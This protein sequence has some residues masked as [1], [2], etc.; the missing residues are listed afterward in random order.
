MIVL[1]SINMT[2]IYYKSVLVNNDIGE[3]GAYLTVGHV[4]R[5]ALFCLVLYTIFTPVGE[6][7]G[8]T[9]SSLYALFKKKLLLLI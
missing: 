9:I 8:I 5:P 6:L 4:G 3:G 2:G 1:F 7:L